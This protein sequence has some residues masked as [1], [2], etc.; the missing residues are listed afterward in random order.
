MYT[1]VYL[2]IHTSQYLKIYSVWKGTTKAVERL[3]STGLPPA[4]AMH[5]TPRAKVTDPFAGPRR[6]SFPYSI[7]SKSGISASRARAG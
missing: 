2:Y 3:A 7:S 1:H 5:D 6:D 4:P